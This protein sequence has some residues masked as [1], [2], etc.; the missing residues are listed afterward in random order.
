[1]IHL[2]SESNADHPRLQ[3]II[4]IYHKQPVLIFPH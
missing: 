4:S 1:M 3:T 2:K